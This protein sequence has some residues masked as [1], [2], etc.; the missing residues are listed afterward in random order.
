M[1]LQL[2]RLRQVAQDAT[3]GELRID[4]VLECVT[5]EPTSLKIPCGSYPLSLYDSP[6]R[7]YKV[8]LLHDVDKRSMIEIHIG[9]W[10]KD[11]RG[12]ILVGR[13]ASEGAIEHSKDAFERLMSKLKL[14][15]L[16]EIM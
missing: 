5:L 7:G 9:N 8:P 3:I 11:S 2:R 6:A 10:P 13:K 1:R 15:A 12:C 16:I 4:G 14:P